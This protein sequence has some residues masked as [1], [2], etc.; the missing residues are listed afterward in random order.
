MEYIPRARLF[1]VDAYHSMCE[2]GVFSPEA[3]FE[4]ID[5]EIFD[6][7]PTGSSHAAMDTRL[8]TLL[9]LA[10]GQRAIVRCRLPIQLGDMSEPQPDLALVL[11]REDH[12]YEHHPIAADTLLAIQVSDMTL[13]FDLGR[14]MALYARHRIPELWVI[15]LKRSRL[16]LFRQPSGDEYLESPVLD[17]PCSM[18]ME[19][20]PDVTLDTSSLF[21]C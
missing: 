8:S 3:R 1:T 15:D 12:Y 10:V 17:A 16:H 18:S 20:L 11:P 9:V 7:P 19:R 5:G 21:G 14:R 13:S 2:N 6:I 4:L